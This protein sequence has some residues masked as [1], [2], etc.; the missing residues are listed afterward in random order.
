M[1]LAS[2][3]VDHVRAVFDNRECS[4]CGSRGQTPDLRTQLAAVTDPVARAVLDIHG[5]DW[6]FCSVCVQESV[7]LNAE[8]PCPTVRVVAAALGITVTE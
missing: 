8:Y 6:G 7:D 3:T 4:G 2:C 5:Y 1:T